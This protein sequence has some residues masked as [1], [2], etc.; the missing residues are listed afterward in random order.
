MLRV[1]KNSAALSASVLAERAVAFFLPWF[2]VRTQGNELWGLYNTALPF[3]LIASPFAY[4][5]LDQLLPRV[6]ARRSANPGQLLGS[7]LF[8]TAAIGLV[9]TA[10]AL[11]LTLLLNYPDDITRLIFI[12]VASNVVPRAEATMFESVIGGLERMELIILVRFPATVLRTAGSI[13]LLTLG[14]GLGSLFVVLGLYHLLIS[15]AYLYVLSR[16]IPGFRLQLERGILQEL[17]RKALPFVMII[18]TGETFRQIDRI[19]LSKIW[20]TEAVGYYAAGTMLI[21]IMYMLAPAIMSAIFPSI[22]RLYVRSVSLFAQWA[23]QLFVII[24]VLIFPSALAIIAFARAIVPLVF[25]PVYQPSVTVL[26][27]VA[28]GLVPAYLARLLYRLMLASDRERLA[29]RTS[30][31]KGMVNIVLAAL[32]IPRHGIIGASVAAA[33]IELFGFLQNLFYVN[34]WVVPLD[35]KAMLVRPGIIMLMSTLI[36][37]SLFNWNSLV[38]WLCATIAF[39]AGILLSRTL[40]WAELVTLAQEKQ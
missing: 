20:N 14:Y 17:A 5:G 35:L 31:S 24:L 26:Q 33:S 19:F 12:A 6:V 9:V 13:L 21:E 4:W 32:L 25:G 1:A 23:V 7:A 8:L 29:V 18:F 38:A 3:V 30:F 10:L 15:A 40:H 16:I 37:V 2:I 34:R 22:S 39:V 27:I 36:F 28:L 11:V